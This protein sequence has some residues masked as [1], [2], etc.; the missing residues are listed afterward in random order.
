MKRAAATSANANATD[1][2][3]EVH[4][5]GLLL[6]READHEQDP[7]APA[8]SILPL[9]AGAM[10]YWR[11]APEQWGPCLD[12]MKAMGLRIVDTYIPWGVHEVEGGTERA[13]GAAGEGTGRTFDFGERSARLDVA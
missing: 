3:V 1:R 4:P 6:S 2:T 13:E 7:L 8:T 5:H 10:L 9:W 12:A 11:H